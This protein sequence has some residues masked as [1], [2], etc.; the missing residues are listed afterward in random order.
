METIKEKVLKRYKEVYDKHKVAMF[1]HSGLDK[2]IEEAID[3][4]LVEA[5]KEFI[6]RTKKGICII[7]NKKDNF[8]KECVCGDCS[9]RWLEKKGELKDYIKLAEVNRVIDK[10]KKKV[11][12]VFGK[13]EGKDWVLEKA[14]PEEIK[15]EI[16]SERKLYILDAEQ[17]KILLRGKK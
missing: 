16:C 7:C 10:E 9:L 5:D 14:C 8:A 4:T 12:E 13:F 3:L 2:A 15:C 1:F 6:R 11:C 17:L